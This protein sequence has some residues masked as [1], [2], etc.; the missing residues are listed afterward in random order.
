MDQNKKK[1]KTPLISV[2]WVAQIVPRPNC[3]WPKKN[4]AQFVAEPKIFWLIGLIINENN[5]NKTSDYMP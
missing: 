2:I 4:K 3:S 5:N 1:K